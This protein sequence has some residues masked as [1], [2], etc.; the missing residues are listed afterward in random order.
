KRHEWMRALQAGAF[1]SRRPRGAAGPV[2]G[3]PVRSSIASGLGALER[4]VRP[5]FHEWL[6]WVELY[7]EILIAPKLEYRVEKL[8]V[9]RDGV[10]ADFAV[11]NRAEKRRYVTAFDLERPVMGMKITDDRDRRWRIPQFAGHIH[12]GTPDTF[13]A[14][15]PGDSVR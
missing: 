14:V 8:Y 4:T 13:I 11:T 15:E 7:Y 2:A 5:A 9:Y 1:N 12:Y 10:W 3:Q 6:L